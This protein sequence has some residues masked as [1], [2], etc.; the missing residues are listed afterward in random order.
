MG[1]EWTPSNIQKV[2]LV[3]QYEYT[4]C[5]I[6]FPVKIVYQIYNLPSRNQNPPLALHR[7]WSCP[8]NS[9]PISPRRRPEAPAFGSDEGQVNIGEQQQLR[10]RRPG[11]RVAGR[12]Q[13]GPSPT[14]GGAMECWAPT[15][16]LCHGGTRHIYTSGEHT[17]TCTHA[18]TH[19]F[20]SQI[21]DVQYVTRIK[22]IHTNLF[23]PK[24]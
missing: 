20:L 12:R 4:N 1:T 13:R 9:S 11:A 8:I 14:L 15:S 22:T 16:A 7:T 5:Q 3:K 24:R 17:R 18:H 23:H 6:N 19:T 2:C 21:E 10:A